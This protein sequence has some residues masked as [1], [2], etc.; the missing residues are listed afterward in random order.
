M[1]DEALTKKEQIDRW[2]NATCEYFDIDKDVLLGRA[3]HREATEA[4]S[5][6][7]Y[8]LYFNVGLTYKYIGEIFDNRHH[9]TVIYDVLHIDTGHVNDVK[10][11]AEKKKQGELLCEN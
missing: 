8:L 7:M 10:D 5:V 4:R 9:S 1:T 2:L 3:K 6:A 11:L